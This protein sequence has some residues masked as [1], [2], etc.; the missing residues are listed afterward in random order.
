MPRRS[1]SRPPVDTR[2]AVRLDLCCMYEAHGQVLAYQGA[3][4]KVY[5]KACG[6]CL[7][8]AEDAY[9]AKQAK[10][11]HSWA[12]DQSKAWREKIAAALHA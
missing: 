8:D 4:G 1:E 5:V 11:W 3:D 6:I 9:A 12:E 10:A 7:Q 2:L